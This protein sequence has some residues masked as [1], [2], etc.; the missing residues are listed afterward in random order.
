MY[1]KNNTNAQVIP[2]TPSNIDLNGNIKVNKNLTFGI[3]KNNQKNYSTSG[4]DENDI[5]QSNP[6][7]S[8]NVN[9]QNVQQNVYDYKKNT[10][11]KF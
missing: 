8:V 3:V 5:P 4:N 11:S 7:I 9:I 1:E 10:T 2:L 6:I